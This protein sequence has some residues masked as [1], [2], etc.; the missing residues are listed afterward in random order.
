MSTGEVKRFAKRRLGRELDVA[1]VGLGCMGM[2]SVYGPASE[3]E[4]IGAI[5]RLLDLGGNLL[6]TAD[7]YGPE[8]NERLV[9]R[10]VAGRRDEVVIATKFGARSLEIPG[11]APDGRPE[12]VPR[13]CEASLRRL[14]VDCIDVYYLH[15]VDPAVPI[16]ETVGAMGM[17]VTAGKVRHLGVSEAAAETVRRAHAVHPLTVV[18]SEL[19]LW[20]REAE[21]E[22]LPTLRELGIGFVAFSPLGRGFLTGTITSPDDL[23]HD[24]TRRGNPRFQGDNFTRNLRLVE[25]VRRMAADRGCTAAQIALAWVLTRG[26]SV[27]VIPGTTKSHRVEENVSAAAVGLS[28]SEVELLDQA[29]PPGSAS[30]NRYP[31]ALMR[32]VDG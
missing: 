4:A 10:A 5:R 16:E 13:A 28:D 8:S 19:S 3:D 2:A 11:R 6:D 23:R 12:Y 7:V 18:Q 14:G 25:T 26:Q 15:R 31:D 17:L 27:V 20:T 9:G 21:V 29:F 1:P 24:D 30:G 32:F 22:V